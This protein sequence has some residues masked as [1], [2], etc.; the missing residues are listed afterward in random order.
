MISYAVDRDQLCFDPVS[1]RI[2]LRMMSLQALDLY[3]ILD[4]FDD[5]TDAASNN[6]IVSFAH[7][8]FLSTVFLRYTTALPRYNETGHLVCTLYGSLKVKTLPSRLL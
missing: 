5:E 6:L 4:P 8:K 7:R 1:N 2:L 3:P